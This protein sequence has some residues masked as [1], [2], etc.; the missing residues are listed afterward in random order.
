[1]GDSSL[2]PSLRYIKKTKNKRE[3]L[4]IICSSR[5][6]FVPLPR[7]SKKFKKE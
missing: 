5:F 6:F 7:E 3:V 2:L 4:R 1:M